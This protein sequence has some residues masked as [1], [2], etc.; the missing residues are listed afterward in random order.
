MAIR[1]CSVT[2]HANGVVISHF[3]CDKRNT[4]GCKLSRDRSVIDTLSEAST[5]PRLIEA[6]KLAMDNEKELNIPDAMHRYPHPVPVDS[7]G[8]KPG[9]HCPIVLLLKPRIGWFKIWIRKHFCPVREWPGRSG[10][11]ESR[12][13][14]CDVKT[15]IEL[16]CCVAYLL[17]LPIVTAQWPV[18]PALLFPL[19]SL[20]VCLQTLSSTITPLTIQFGHRSYVVRSNLDCWIKWI[21]LWWLLD[22]GSSRKSYRSSMRRDNATVREIFHNEGLI[23]VFR[24]LDF[25]QSIT[26]LSKQI[27]N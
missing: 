8:N 22:G 9:I 19:F 14:N 26:L 23:S 21:L 27:K 13:A 6:Q 17:S 1:F 24:K 3:V 12:A 18:F 2:F 5:P 15:L 16:S 11:S 20:T 7:A 10:I 25:A 4:K